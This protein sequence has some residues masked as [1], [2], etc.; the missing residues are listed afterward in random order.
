MFYVLFSSNLLINLN[1]DLKICDFGLARV[2][3]P[4]HD[5]TGLLTEYVAT[6]WY[7][8]P[9]I[10]LNA[11]SYTQAID[12][13]AVGCIFGEMIC[14]KS[15]FPGTDYHNQLELIL[16]LVGT[17]SSEDLEYI[18]SDAARRYVARLPFY[19]GYDFAQLFTTAS[20]PMIDLLR[21]MLVF[22]PDRRITAAE[23]LEHEYLQGYHDVSLEPVAESPFAFEFEVSHAV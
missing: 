19:P 2:A 10:M 18:K 21:R 13:W 17:P 5:H 9:E 14:R 15:L 4:S 16:R 3:D 22:H 7:R 6:R 1:C 8:A 11:R 12:M 20:P 23:A